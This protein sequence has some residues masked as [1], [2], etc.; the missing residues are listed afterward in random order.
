MTVQNHVPHS[1]IGSILP[2]FPPK[3][4]P[5]PPLALVSLVSKDPAIPSFYLILT[6]YCL[7]ALICDLEAPRNQRVF[8]ELALW[9]GFQV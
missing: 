5:P 2:L 7:M 4:F 9:R 1:G 3:P 6:S 8:K